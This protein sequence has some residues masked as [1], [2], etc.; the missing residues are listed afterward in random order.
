LMNLGYGE[1]RLNDRDTVDHIMKI[2]FVQPDISLKEYALKEES[3]LFKK[4]VDA[5]LISLSKESMIGSPDLLIWP[6]MTDDFTLQNDGRLDFLYKE[7]TSKGPDLLI[8]TSF[9]DYSNKSRKNIAFILENNGDMTEPYM[10]QRI[11]PFSESAT[12]SPGHRMVTLPTSKKGDVGVMI[13]LESMYP[14]IAKE[15]A[16]SGGKA[17]ISISTDASFGN[18]I[19][20]YVHAAQIVFRAIENGLYSAHVGNTGPSLI[21]DNRGRILTY[22]PYGVQGFGKADIRI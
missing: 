15:E 7:I 6:E 4:I 20:P 8:G 19:I 11:F 5:K 16:R 1:A 13:C 2:A 22:I 10:K 9:M 14:D 12:Y 18:S 21:C 3:G 17:L